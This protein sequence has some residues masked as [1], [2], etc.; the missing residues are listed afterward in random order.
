MPVHRTTRRSVAAQE[1]QPPIDR[2]SVA[3]IHEYA[4]AV[5]DLSQGREVDPGTVCILHS[6]HHCLSLNMSFRPLQSKNSRIKLRSCSR[7]AGYASIVLRELYTSDISPVCL[8]PL[9]AAVENTLRL[10]TSQ[11]HASARVTVR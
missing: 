1:Q 6:L 11:P 10:F 9:L 3:A 4:I 2:M 8:R 5:D 7:Y